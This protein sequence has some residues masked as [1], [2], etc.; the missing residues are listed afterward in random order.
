MVN[1]TNIGTA[2][3]AEL[4]GLLRDRMERI[5][6]F[7]NA[8]TP[9]LTE[10]NCLN[11]TFKNKLEKKNSHCGLLDKGKASNSDINN[12]HKNA[13]TATYFRSRKR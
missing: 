13:T 6:A 4:G 7:L 3:K 11:K 2:S 8:Y 10:L 1:Q 12:S 5:W 9:S